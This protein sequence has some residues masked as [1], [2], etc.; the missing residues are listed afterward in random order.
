M[1][2]SKQNWFPTLNQAL[3]SE[4]LTDLWPFG[5]NVSY[6]ENVRFVTECNR[7]VT[8]FRET[9]GMYERPVHYLTK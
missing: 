1:N 2:Y 7:L 3:E 9:N 5:L 4:G 6:G 8:I